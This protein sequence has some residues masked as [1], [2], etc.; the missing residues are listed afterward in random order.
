MGYLKEIVNFI[1][2]ILW[3]YILIFGLI[4][5]GIFMTVKLKFLQFT[6]V[7]PALK[8]MIIDIIKKKP[9]E[10]GKMSPFQA[11]STAVAAQVGTGNIVG[12]ATAIASGGPGAAFWMIVSAFFGMAT[13]FSESVLAQKYRDVKEGEVTG[14]PAYYIKNGLKSK[15]LAMFFA[16]TCIIALGIV[17][18]MVQSNSVAGSVNDAFGIPVFAITIVLTIVV[19]RILVGGMEKIAS[20]SEKVVPAM[21]G[22]YILGSIVIVIMNIENFI[23]AI[24]LILIGAFSPE[25]I[26]GGVLGITVQQTVRFGLARGLFSNEAGMGSTPHSHAVADVPHPAEQGFTAMIGVFIST[27]LIC[28]STVMVNIT[29]GAYNTN[30]SAAEMAKGATVMTQNSFAVGFGSLGGMFLSVCLSFF[31]LTTIVGWYFFAEANVKFVFNSKP[32]TINIFK[33]IALIALILGTMIDAD[34]AWQLA[35]MFMG[36]MAVPNI[37]ALFFLS[38]DV[39]EILDDYDRCVEKGKI[40]WDYECPKLDEKK[41]KKGSVLREGLSTTIIK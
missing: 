35:D 24:K 26:G 25:A 22:L 5:I 40:H 33:T 28:L 9:V 34:F 31:A 12:V 4:G 23:P 27:F 8:K 41:K 32:R 18:I 7:F 10:E 15:G 39:K 13:I 37:I 36:I 14:G 2:T 17:G 1:N 6:R 30:I 11:L 29:S 16:I 3:D 19:F 21:A 20:F 38:K